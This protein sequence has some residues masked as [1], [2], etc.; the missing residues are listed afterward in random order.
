VSDIL[1]PR[2]KPAE[3]PVLAVAVPVAVLGVSLGLWLLSMPPHMQSRSAAVETQAASIKAATEGAGDL[4][5]FPEGSVCEGEL[6]DAAKQKLKS[7]LADSG[8]KVAAFDLTDI[9][10]AGRTSLEAY[11][12]SFK[13]SGGYAQAM[14]ALAAMDAARPRLF[15]DSLAL[16]NHVD[17]VELEVE[18]R[19]FCR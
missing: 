7:A 19:L 5:T 1:L 8:L 16:R 12:Y 11:R 13:G 14:T 17:A 6:S 10:A 18:G 3:F 4:K 9:G 15:V 2:K